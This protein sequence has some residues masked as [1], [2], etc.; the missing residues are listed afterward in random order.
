[1]RFS[2]KRLLC[3]MLIITA[4]GV[5]V[6]A[7][8]RQTKP[9]ASLPD[10]GRPVARMYDISEAVRMLVDVAVAH[11]AVN[12][13]ALRQRARQQV[14]SALEYAVNRSALPRELLTSP[15]SAA[16]RVEWFG[17]H[18]VV[19]A[20]PD[21]HEVALQ[22]LTELIRA[23]GQVISVETR[24][25][26]FAVRGA[27]SDQSGEQLELLLD[28]FLGGRNDVALLKDADAADVLRQALAMGVSS[29]VI[30][31]RLT[32]LGGTSAWV[33]TGNQQAYVRD[34]VEIGRAHV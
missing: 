18:A 23:K 33:V 25:L 1:M 2:G 30:A 16:A 14:A 13:D 8:L 3:V 10:A 20:V 12:D 9:A 31:P 28:K 17:D 26:D 7:Y 29:Q 24:I 27:S 4:A 6:V 22:T 34:Y 32:V 11:G 5:A 21:A 19:V 15:M